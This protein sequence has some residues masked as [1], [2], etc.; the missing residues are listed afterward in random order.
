[1]YASEMMKVTTAKGVISFEGKYKDQLSLIGTNLVAGA[2]RGSLRRHGFFSIEIEKGKH[3][4]AAITGFRPGN[5]DTH[6]ISYDFLVPINWD[7][8]SDEPV[9][10]LEKPYIA[11]PGRLPTMRD[12]CLQVFSGGL[13]YTHRQGELGKNQV[14]VADPDLLCRFI[15]GEIDKAALDAEARKCE[16]EQ[17]AIEECQHLQ[18]IIRVHETSIDNLQEA[19]LKLA[20]EKECLQSQLEEAQSR[21]AHTHDLFMSKSAELVLALQTIAFWRKAC[22]DLVALIKQGWWVPDR[23]LKTLSTIAERR[24]VESNQELVE[25][26]KS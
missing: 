9:V 7:D 5:K 12:A 13:M 18:E 1:M 8:N 26:I 21:D 6:S 25:I 23:Y 11:T 14:F 20:R 15:T 24:A 16:E 19:S 17:S 2:E 3:G 22:T 10:E 4:I